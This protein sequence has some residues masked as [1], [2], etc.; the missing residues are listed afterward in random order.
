MLRRLEIMPSA[1]SLH[2]LGDVG[3]DGADELD[4]V[5]VGDT[6]FV[7]V[8]SVSIRPTVVAQLSVVPIII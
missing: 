6:P 3:I 8:D 5:N 7:T 4:N 2:D 1:A